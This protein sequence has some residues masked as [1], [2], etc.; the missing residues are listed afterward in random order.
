MSTSILFNAGILGPQ[1]RSMDTLRS[2]VINTHEPLWATSPAPISLLSRT[3]SRLSLHFTGIRRRTHSPAATP[4]SGNSQSKMTVATDKKQRPHR[5]LPTTASGLPSRATHPRR[6]THG[7]R[8]AASRS[9]SDHPAH[10]A[11]VEYPPP[12][13]P[14]T[15]PPPISAPTLHLLASAQPLASS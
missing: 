13:P 8:L 7:K 11:W 9:T 2:S 14:P 4:S 1:A 12:P 15:P 10:H 3:P 5:T 6:G